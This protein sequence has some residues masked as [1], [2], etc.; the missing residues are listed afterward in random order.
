[1]VQV[2]LRDITLT[3]GATAILR[4]VSFTVEAG[5]F[6]VL[7]G[8]S[9]CGKSTL[10]RLIAGLD[11][12]ASGEILIDGQS[13]VHVPAARRN[14][15]MVFQGYALYPHMTVFD[16]IAFALR[17]AKVPAAEIQARVQTAAKI[18]QLGDC[19]QRK[20][21]SLSGGQRQ[22]V[23]I[24]RAIVKKPKVFLFDEPLSNLDASLRAETRFEIAKLHRDMGSASMLYVTH[25]QVE[26]MTLADRIVLLR[27]VL[28]S[29]GLGS[30]VQVGRPMDLYHRPANLFAARFI[31]TPGMNLFETRVAGL[32]DQGVAFDLHGQRCHAAVSN[33]GL[34]VGDLITVGIRAEHVQVSLD[35]SHAGDAAPNRV[36]ASVTHIEALGEHSILFTN[37]VGGPAEAL[38]AKTTDESVR[39]GDS[40][41]LHLPASAMHVFGVN[42]GAQVR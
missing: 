28:Q 34:A 29:P 33:A 21:A 19:L 25:D 22:R 6:C 14:V 35:S 5:E 40:V 36:L 42:G 41:V 13:V 10:L 27:P 11:D 9:G 17:R 18:L 1:M 20:P 23:A 37:L 24:G 12:D 2:T 30:I 32:T 38:L 26:A 15:A 39:V 8:P 4:D 31:G 3:R 7:V 16:N